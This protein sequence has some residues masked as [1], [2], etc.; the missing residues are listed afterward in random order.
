MSTSLRSTELRMRLPSTRRR[1]ARGFTLIE[2]LVALA[3]VV[4]GLA[5][6]ATTANQSARTTTYLREKTLAQWI[7]LNRITETRVS[8]TLP[9]EETEGE[10]EYAGRQWRWELERISTAVEGIYRLEARVAP[11]EARE[12]SWVGQATGF[13]GNA[14]LPASPT[15]VPNWVGAPPSGA[16]GPP[17]GEPR[18]QPPPPGGGEPQQ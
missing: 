15:P 7:A 16:G 6:L 11:E 9:S 18:P 10:I 4:V 2:V 5:A 13:V 12:G 3:I 17:G 1:A 14:I 8:G